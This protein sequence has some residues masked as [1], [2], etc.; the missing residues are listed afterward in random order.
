MKP[1]VKLLSLTAALVLLIGCLPVFSASAADNAAALSV[2]FV[3]EAGNVITETLA[4]TTVSAQIILSGD[5]QTVQAASLYLSAENATFGAVTKDD[6]F[7]EA[8]SAE[9]EDGV[10]AVALYASEG[11]ALSNGVL[12]SVK[13][14]VGSDPVSVSLVET[15]GEV[16]TGVADAN[17]ASLPLDALTGATLNIGTSAPGFA[18]AQLVLSSSIGINF[19]VKDETLTNY[20]AYDSYVKINFD[21]DRDGIL[22]EVILKP[23]STTVSGIPCKRY[24]F[25]GIAPDNMGQPITA[26]LMYVDDEGEHEGLALTYSVTDYITNTLTSMEKY[27]SSYPN[28]KGLSTLLADLLAYGR[29]SEAYTGKSSITMSTA[30]ETLL[31]KASDPT[32]PVANTAASNKK[33]L[34]YAPGL[35]A[36]TASVQWTSVGLNLRDNAAILYLFKPADGKSISDY[37]IK[38]EV[39]GKTYSASMSEANYE[40]SYG[41]YAYRFRELGPCDMGKTVRAYFVDRDDNVASGYLQYSVESYAYACYQNRTSKPVLNDLTQ[42]LIRYGNS[43]KKYVA[44]LS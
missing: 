5:V 2:R 43:V 38:L 7:D 34:Y 36:A 29:A 16:S 19:Y 1:F 11:V 10:L 17:D 41:A 31:G 18:G 9:H 42:A 21:V 32:V 30:L 12:C 27:P 3:D 35:S 33:A 28:P 14:S 40:D 37:T 22:D 39:D 13:I 26:Q 44:S 24:F 4:N 8:E 23:S 20:G 25:N 6:G 15:V